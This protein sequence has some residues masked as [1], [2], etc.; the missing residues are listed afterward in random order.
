MA[1]FI[2][3]P[4]SSQIIRFYRIHAGFS[5]C[6][7]SAIS[8]ELSA[9]PRPCRELTAD[10]LEPEHIAHLHE[11]LPAVVDVVPGGIRD[12]AGRSRG[13]RH[14]AQVLQI[15]VISHINRSSRM[16]EIGNQEVRVE[17]L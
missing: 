3:V 8:Y 14:Y 6:G 12:E 11:E 13:L 7:L 9:K 1:A 10:R 2:V 15:A 16:H 17:L 5:N 4:T